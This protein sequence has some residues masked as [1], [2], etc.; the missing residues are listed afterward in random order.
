MKIQMLNGIWKYRIGNGKTRDITVPFST[1]PVG[2]SECVKIFNLEV[3]AKTTIV[4]FDGITYAA[5]VYVNG[6]YLGEMLPYSEY[7]FDITE[8]VKAKDNELLV[9]IEDISPT[10]GPSEGWENFGGIIRDVSLVFHEENYIADV[11]FHA[12]L[13]NG[14]K[15]AAFTVETVSHRGNGIFHIAL[16]YKDAPVLEYC[17]SAGKEYLVK[18]LTDVHL[19]SPDLPELYQLKVSLSENGNAVDTYCCNVGFREFKCDRHRFLLNGKPLFL[20]GV[21]KHEMIGDS[22]HCP[23]EEQIISDLRM[24]KDTGCNFVRLVHYPHNKKTIDIADRLGLM[25]S[26]EPGLWWSDTAEPEV[27]AG[28]FE[29]LRRTILRDRNHPS[30]VFWLCFNEC[31]F[32]EQYLVHSAQIC[33]KYDPTR[34]VSGANCMNDEDTLKYF[35]ICGFDFYTMHPYAQTMDRAKESARILHDKPL[36]FTEWGGYYVYDNPNLLSEFMREMYRLYLADSD[37]G[38]LAG[39]FFWEWSELNDYNRG[40]PACVDGN[41]CEGLVDKYRNPHLIYTAF[42]ESLKATGQ[43]QNDD[44]WCDSALQ[45]VA[46]QNTVPMICDVEKFQNILNQINASEMQ[47]GKM[48]KRR[49]KHGPVL[50]GVDGFHAVPIVLQDNDC[51]SFD[52]HFKTDKLSVFGMTSFIKGYPLGGDYGERVAE[53]IVTFD[54]KCQEKMIFRNG[55]D[56]TT[57]FELNGSSRINPVAESAIRSATFGYDK[58]FERYV[59]NKIELSVD[60]RKSINNISICSCNNG[61]AMLIYGIIYES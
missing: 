8:F 14:Y 27:S 20:K 60:H 13:M 45:D 17:Q 21:C 22:G 30:I 44:F 15:D 47:S 40:R 58:N 12:E 57:V 25:V 41:L 2:H 56:I 32:T 5:K 61:Y 9:E 33:R 28:S 54:D 10:F 26:E 1:L 4:K 52:C 7:E 18:T 37:E 3:E 43:Q 19:W 42:C 50:Q 35:N 53:M 36:L 55:I 34:L 6:I 46:N 51:A 11:F 49:L 38:S 24:I 31:K 23:T 48:R 16:Y 59:L 39:A 29:V